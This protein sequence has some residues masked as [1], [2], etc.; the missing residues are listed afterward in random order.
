MIIIIYSTA[1]TVKS[2]P[3]SQESAAGRIGGFRGIAGKFKL[4]TWQ[5]DRL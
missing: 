2:E 3:S 1:L 4:F 5:D